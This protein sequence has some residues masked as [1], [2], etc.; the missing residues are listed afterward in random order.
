MPD[1]IRWGILGTGNIAG[2]F[3]KALPATRTGRLFGV[4][5]RSQASADAFARQFGVERAY[6][7]YE[8]ILADA[9]I[10]AV[11]ISTPHPLHKPWAIAAAQ[12]KKHILCEKPLG[13]NAAE[14]QEMI[15]A[16]RANDVFLME[17][18]MYRCHP[19]IAQ[20]IDL[21][22]GGAI[23]EVRAIAASF[24]FM[25][26]DP[27]PAG[28]LLNKSLGGG[29][30]LDV[31]CYPVSFSRLVAGAAAGLNASIDPLEVKGIAH[32]GLSG[33][34]E[35]AAAVLR[36]PND[37]LAQVST[38][39]LLDQEN[40]AR[41]YG[42]KGSLYLPT[43]WVPQEEVKLVLTRAGRDPEDILVRSRE[44]AYSLE[45]DVLGDHL[46]A[47]QAPFPAMSWD[48]TLGNLRTLDAWRREVGLEYEGERAGG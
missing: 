3:A 2:V 30:I 19:Q 20:V 35:W 42:T 14:G 31:G 24:S 44:N 37:V 23:G 38:G 10:D 15:D 18:F 28:R 27:N 39:V 13:M 17:A 1:R 46:A 36:F 48:D 16:A 4:G 45:A 9:E 5:S 43:P 47:R 22:R 11:Y 12:A 7:S 34:D 33:V 40:S 8:A 21:I 6:G 29:G 26:P 25:A 32:L 41:V